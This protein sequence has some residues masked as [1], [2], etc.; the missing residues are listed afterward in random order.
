MSSSLHETGLPPWL[1]S[2]RMAV[3]GGVAFAFLVL[4]VLNTVSFV[5][6]L[7][8][9]TDLNSAPLCFAI[10]RPI[11]AGTQLLDRN[12]YKSKRMIAERNRD[13]AKVQAASADCQ[14][15]ACSSAAREG[16]RAAIRSYLM[17][18][19]SAASGSF[20]RH[21]ETGLDF[22]RWIY[23]EDEDREIIDG[24]RKRYGA[25]LF[26]LKTMDDHGHD[27]IAATRML[28]FG[29]AQAFKPCARGE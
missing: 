5:R 27:Y 10:S 25:N 24:L 28:L 14:L 19:S 23:D 26:D 20:A 18:R 11:G 13:V 22:A 21:G 12:S 16:Y 17:T 4:L 7:F 6:S 8:D 2:P 1:F 29:N 3:A 9:R 15:A